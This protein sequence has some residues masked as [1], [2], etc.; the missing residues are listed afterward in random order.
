MRQDAGVRFN[1]LFS[2]MYGL[3]LQYRSACLEN[4]ESQ[5]NDAPKQATNIGFVQPE[6]QGLGRN[7]APPALF[8]PLRRPSGTLSIKD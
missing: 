6:I 8:G 1:F 2:H 3:P 5:T 7:F 4:R